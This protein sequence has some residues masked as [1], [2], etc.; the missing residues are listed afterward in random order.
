MLF[1]WLPNDLTTQNATSHSLS[2]SISL[3]HSNTHTRAILSP[4]ICVITFPHA[5]T[6]TH[7]CTFKPIALSLSFKHT[8]TDHLSIIHMC[9]HSLSLSFYLTHT[10]QPSL[11]QL[12][13]PLSSSLSP[14]FYLK[15]RVLERTIWSQNDESTFGR[16]FDLLI[17]VH[18]ETFI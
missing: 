5:F 8:Q 10:N 7:F 1:G 3:S 15:E 11:T 16:C 2:L 14:F 13:V 12:C 18:D 4:H 17:I 9:H 6:H